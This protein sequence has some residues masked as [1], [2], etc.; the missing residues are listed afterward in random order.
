M[1]AIVA[2][3]LRIE[4]P[5]LQTTDRSLKRRVVSAATG[6]RIARD[7]RNHVVVTALDGVSFALAAGERVALV[8]HNGSGKTTL[9]RAIAG[10][11]EP[12]SGEL[13]VTGTISSFIDIS[14]GFDPDATGR[15]NVYL[16]GFIMGMTRADIEA[17][18]DDIQAFSGLGEYLELP[19][20]SYSSGMLLRLA[21]AV[22]TSMPRDIVLMDEWLSVG[23]ADFAARAA[24]RLRAFVER[25]SILVL[26]TH[27]DALAARFCNRRIELSQGR[28]VSD[29]RLP[30]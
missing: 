6:G 28:V 15:E 3:D 17:R 11:Y 13:S 1:T 5:I 16:R 18:M 8:G 27:S 26:A 12:T 25:T 29:T 22:A 23:D 20:R 24:D 19:L 4:Y 10:V 14:I 7:A 30:A 21:F 2:R 9:L